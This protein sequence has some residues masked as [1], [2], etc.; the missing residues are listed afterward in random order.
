MTEAPRSHENVGAGDALGDAPEERLSVGHDVLGFEQLH[1][2]LE[3]GEE[4]GLLGGVSVGPIL[5]ER[6][7]DLGRR[8]ETV[9]RA[10]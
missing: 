10:G 7:D 1:E 9:L 4:P 6:G 3:L 2:V 8:G 5:E